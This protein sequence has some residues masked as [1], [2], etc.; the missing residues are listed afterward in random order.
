M[1]PT[2]T[3]EKIACYGGLLV[4]AALVAFTIFFG[5]RGDIMITCIL[6]VAGMIVMFVHDWFFGFDNP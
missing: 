4:L 2:T 5:I 6:G 1:I 3:F